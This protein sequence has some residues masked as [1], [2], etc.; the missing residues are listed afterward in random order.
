MPW[1]MRPYKWRQRRQPNK[2]NKVQKR[3]PR[4]VKKCIK[5]RCPDWKTTSPLASSRQIKRILRSK[6]GLW[7]SIHGSQ[8]LPSDWLDIR[9]AKIHRSQAPNHWHW[10]HTLMIMSSDNNPHTPWLNESKQKTSIWPNQ[11]TAWGRSFA[12]QPDFMASRVKTQSLKVHFWS[13]SWLDVPLK[14]LQASSLSFFPKTSL[15]PK[16]F[17]NQSQSETATLQWNS[18]SIRLPI[19]SEREPQGAADFFKRIC[20][21]FASSKVNAFWLQNC[22]RSLPRSVKKKNVWTTQTYL[23]VAFVHQHRPFDSQQHF[24]FANHTCPSPS[25]TYPPTPQPRNCNQWHFQR[26][27]ISIPWIPGPT[28]G[29]THE[30]VLTRTARLSRNKHCNETSNRNDFNRHLPYIP[31]ISWLYF[32]VLVIHQLHPTIQWCQWCLFEEA[33]ARAGVT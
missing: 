12:P 2:D 7:V 9:G 26:G 1:K 13:L 15:G 31:V 19:Q 27:I 24:H 21:K 17:P 30:L 28:W 23:D 16:S 11:S 18:L 8:N 5:S 22:Q 10:F 4:L 32:F 6:R 3:P 20:R 29:K 25:A 14:I 33:K